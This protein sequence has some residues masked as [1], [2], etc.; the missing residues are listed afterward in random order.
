MTMHSLHYHQNESQP[1]F[2]DRFRQ[3]PQ[4]PQAPQALQAP[5]A[6]QVQPQT[7]SGGQPAIMDHLPWL[8]EKRTTP[9]PHF[10]DLRKKQRCDRVVHG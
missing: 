1:F 9:G 3:A 5:Q 4:A 8:A 7:P 10:K 2:C 6:P